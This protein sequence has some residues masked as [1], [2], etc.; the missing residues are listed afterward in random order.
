MVRDDFF[1]LG[2]DR[3]LRAERVSRPRPRSL[4]PYE[5][6]RPII[7]MVHP[8]ACHDA[9]CLTFYLIAK[10]RAPVVLVAREDSSETIDFHRRSHPAPQGWLQTEPDLQLRIG[11]YQLISF[12]ADTPATVIS[13]VL[14]PNLIIRPIVFVSTAK[15][16]EGGGAET[17]GN[18]IH[19]TLPSGTH[20]TPTCCHTHAW[21]TGTAGN[22]P[23]Y[24]AM[25]HSKKNLN[26]ISVRLST[27]PSLCP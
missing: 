8:P 21:L 4:L 24:F 11:Q 12:G 10:L 14:R 1:D 22:T 9:A 23:R 5:L 16:R 17:P 2:N 19:L 25:H 7:N 18:L 27:P 15:N 3:K 20:K 26:Y 13:N 6:R